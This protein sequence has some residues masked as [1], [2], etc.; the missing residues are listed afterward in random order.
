MGMPAAKQGDKIIVPDMHIILVPAHPGPPVPTLPSSHLFT[1]G[2][3]S[4]TVKIMGLPAATV[5]STSQNTPPHSPHQGG[6]FRK[7]PTNRTTIHIGR[8]TMMT[9]GKQATR[10]GDTA[11]TCN[12]PADFLGRV[13]AGG[14]VM[15]G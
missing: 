9:K 14:T 8:R 4:P 6:S 7:P 10:N 15:L 11:L 1:G 13:V 5:G 2:N 3:L 12:D